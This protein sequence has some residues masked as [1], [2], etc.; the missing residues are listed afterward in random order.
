MR[1]GPV[2]SWFYLRRFRRH[3]LAI[4]GCAAPA[5]PA[6]TVDLQEQ[7]MGVAESRSVFE[8]LQHL[9]PGAGVMRLVQQFGQMKMGLGRIGRIEQQER[10]VGPDG[11]PHVAQ[12]LAG[13]A[14]VTVRRGPPRGFRRG[15]F[16]AFWPRPPPLPRSPPPPPSHLTLFA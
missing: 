3:A 6:L 14:A 8:R 7:A 12:S 4:L 9:A 13:Q 1:A 2:F 5:A 11:R 16:G 15:T 10:L